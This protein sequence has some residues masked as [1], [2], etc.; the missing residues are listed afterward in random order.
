MLDLYELERL[1]SNWLKARSSYTC[2]V[3]PRFTTYPKYKQI[4]VEIYR[5]DEKSNKSLIKVVSATGVNV[6][7]MWDTIFDKMFA[8]FMEIAKNVE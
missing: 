4:D 7:K 2:S 5:V 1:F 6:E 8:Y 3:T